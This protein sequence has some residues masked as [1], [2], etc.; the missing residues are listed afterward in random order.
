MAGIVKSAGIVLISGK[1][2]AD[3]SMANC[4]KSKAISKVLFVRTLQHPF[5]GTHCFSIESNSL[6]IEPEL[7]GRTV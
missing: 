5:F 3:A 7:R 2:L 1:L 6:T 4:V